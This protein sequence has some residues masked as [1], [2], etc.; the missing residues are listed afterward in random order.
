MKPV[1]A[2]GGGRWCVEAAARL[3]WKT[4][5][6]MTA[7][8]FALTFA[9]TFALKAHASIDIKSRKPTVMIAWG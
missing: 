1:G 6:V 8:P 7:L 4:I 9:L 3:T 5:D 2:V